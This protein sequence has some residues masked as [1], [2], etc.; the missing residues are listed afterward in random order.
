MK[1]Q[2]LAIFTRTPMHI[3]AGSS[4]GAVDLPIIRE[5]HT[6]YPVIPGS[7]LKGVLADL[8]REE[9]EEIVPDDKS[10]KPVDEAVSTGKNAPKP[11]RV[12]KK[13]SDLA[14]LFGADRDP[15]DAQSGKLLIGEGKILA[16]PVRSA[17]GGFAWL[18]CPLALSRLKRDAGLAFTLPTLNDADACLAPEC[19]G[20]DGKVILEEYCL[21]RD[22]DVPADLVAALKKLSDD[23]SWQE[24]LAAHLVV[25]SDEFFS[26]FVAN[27][28][29]IAQHVKIN[30]D[31]G[32]AEGGALF[33]QENVP[34]ECLFYVVLN[35][36]ADGMINKL[37]DK[38]RAN[39]SVLQ[40]GADA[41]TG[42]GWCSVNVIN[43]NN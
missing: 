19:M 27:A 11:R 42:L 7:S 2:L 17:K 29:E 9:T 5:R 36:L 33:N 12:R 43:N 10:E 1:Q 41:T 13:D 37:A 30:P 35:E 8:W 32:T 21:K 14:K 38:L 31:T 15:K 39:D 24:E 34:S 6:G 28:C 18:T 16:F 3:G 40:I 22:G 20:F 26:Y 25:V 23:E 4:V